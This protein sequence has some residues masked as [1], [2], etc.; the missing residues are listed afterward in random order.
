VDDARRTYVRE[1]ILCAGLAALLASLLVWLGPPGADVAA[2]AYQRSAFLQHGFALWN[3]FWYAGRY[4]FVTYSLVYYPLAAVVGIKLLAVVTVAASAFA[5]AMV[6]QHEWGATARWSTRAFAVVWPGLVLSG[7][8]PF[9]LGAAL[10][11]L[12]LWMVQRGSRWRFAAFAALSL[13]ASPLAFLLL[14]LVLAGIGLGR[15]SEGRRYVVP[16]AIIAAMGMTEA[17]LWRLFPDGGRYPF[18]WQEL[19]AA[20]V[21]CLLGAS[22]TWR[23]ERAEVL[24]WVFVVYLFACLAAFAIPSALGENVDRL[25]YLAIPVAVLAFSL[26]QW[27]PLPVAVVVLGLATSWNL[28]PLA[29][30]FVK[31]SEDPAV[32]AAYWQPAVGYLR[33]HL[34]L[35]Y[36]VEAVDTAGHWDAVYLPQA[37]VP[38]ARGWFRQ[39]DFP[40]NKLLYSDDELARAAYVS[41]LRGLGI[42]YVVLTDA[43]PDYSARAEAKLLRGGRSGLDVVFRSPHITIYELPH[44]SPIVTGPAP[45]RVVELAQ[46]RAAI[47]VS[48]P[49]VYRVAIRY[50][51]YWSASVGCLDAG[52]DSLIRLRAPAAGRIELLFHVNAR[53]AFAAF[54]GEQPQGCGR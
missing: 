40:Q 4:S 33:S 45:A 11:L 48:A 53:R 30:S 2:H 44:A 18:S 52:K 16:G 47:E 15:R 6:F 25:R 27:R 54:A 13:A 17:V 8:F 29:F 51:P 23:V 37:G 28:T 41:W 3:N 31:T 36:R 32:S 50:S 19:I 5:F 42:R 26:R 14:A 22:I 49:G 43:P 7:A 39:N 24:R 35:S 9:T 38:L 46:A 20:V 21:F 1:A 10:A 34:S 12:A